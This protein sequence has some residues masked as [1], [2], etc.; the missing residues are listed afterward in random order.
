MKHTI[1]K[2]G[3]MLVAY[4]EQ[5]VSVGQISLKTGKFVGATS[6]MIDLHNAFETMK[7]IKPIKEMRVYVVDL[8]DIE[9]DLGSSETIPNNEFMD[10]AEA[11]GNVFTLKGFENS[12]NTEELNLNNCFI[13][14]IVVDVTK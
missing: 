8:N 4:N 5:G 12:I 11:Q 9:K 6:C 2:K 10:I 14:F 7:P 1:K 3:N 13:R